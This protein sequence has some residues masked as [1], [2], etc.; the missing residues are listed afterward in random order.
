[1]TLQAWVDYCMSK[2]GAVQDFPFDKDTLVFKVQE[3]MFSLTSLKR[4][5]AGDH[6][7]NLKCDPQWALELREQYASVTPGYHMN[8]KHW[9]T[10]A[11][12]E[13]ELP[14]ELIYQLIDHSYEL[15]APKKKPQKT[16]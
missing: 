1:M 15:V 11:I 3:K 7:I 14:E 9:N 16:S 2:P 6:S 4:W 13:G 10:V 8:K 12:D 5:E